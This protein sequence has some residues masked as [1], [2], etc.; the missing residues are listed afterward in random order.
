MVIREWVALILWGSLLLLIMARSRLGSEM[1]GFNS[2]EGKT[3]GGNHSQGL[4]GQGFRKIV[5]IDIETI[6]N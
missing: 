3:I 4:R 2:V 5:Y 1:C 6:K